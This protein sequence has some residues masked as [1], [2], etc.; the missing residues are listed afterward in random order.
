MTATTATSATVKVTKGQQ[1]TIDGGKT[2]K[3]PGADAA[4]YT[5][6]GLTP[7]KAYDVKARRAETANYKA[8]PASEVA[9]AKTLRYFSSDNAIAT[10]DENGV[11]TAKAKGVC[12]IQVMARTGL[13]KS[14][15]V[16]VK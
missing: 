1:Y 4:T 16:T 7:G 11:I 5:F 12:T 2:W 15:T 13:T 8:S 6:K 9:R 14:V 10:V 3:T